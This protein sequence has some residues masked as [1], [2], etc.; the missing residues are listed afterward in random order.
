MTGGGTGQGKRKTTVAKHRQETG[1]MPS[2]SGCR[3]QD[4]PGALEDITPGPEGPPEPQAPSPQL[5]GLCHQL[6]V[7]TRLPGVKGETTLQ[8]RSH[9]PK[10]TRFLMAKP[11]NCK[12]H[13]Q[14]KTLL[15]EGD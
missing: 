5:P 6:P 9:L 1:L 15:K 4:G 14:Q 2:A 11:L 13:S 12:I 10:E 3:Q 8:L 7:R